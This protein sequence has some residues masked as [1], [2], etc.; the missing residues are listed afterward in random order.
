M[1]NFQLNEEMHNT[2]QLIQQ[3]RGQS[4]CSLH[5]SSTTGQSSKCIR[6]KF[7]YRPPVLPYGVVFLKNKK[8]H[9]FPRCLL[10]LHITICDVIAQ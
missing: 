8:N 9:M 2:E 4:F 1:M 3:S 10:L 6:Y 5:Q 7:H